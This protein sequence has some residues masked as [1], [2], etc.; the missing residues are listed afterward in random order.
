MTPEMKAEII[1]TLVADKHSG[2]TVGDEKMLEAASDERLE[3]FR[4]AAEARALEVKEVKELKAAEGKQLSQED[5]MKVA[6][7]EL[8]SLI[9]RQQKQETERK[10]DL[11]AVLKTAQ[12]EHSESQLAAMPTDEL[13][14]MARMLKTQVADKRDY[15]GRGVS[16]TMSDGGDDFTPPDP[17]ADGLKALRAAQG[18][19][20]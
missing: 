7:P 3:S 18:I 14:S 1:K 19:V 2:F 16:R 5:F 8:K 9:S 4:V 6:P 15:S 11:V 13:E 20:V 10:A 12:E 17:Y